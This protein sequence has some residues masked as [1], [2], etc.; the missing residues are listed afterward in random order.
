MTEFSSMALRP[1]LIESLRKMGFVTAT[2]VQERSIP[3]LLLGKNVTVRA[4][5]GTGKT[6]AFIV[7]IL[8]MLKP[9]HDIEAIVIAPTRELA[10][11][12]AD[13]ATNVG[14]PLGMRVATIY[15]GA[16]MGS[17]DVCASQRR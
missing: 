17:P 5:S 1:E 3:E 8:Q 10:L 7:P 9:S 2:D 6:A 16:S 14:K 12:V 4:K 11:Q 13:F 15:G